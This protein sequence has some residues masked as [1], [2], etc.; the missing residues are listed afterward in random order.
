MK[1]RTLDQLLHVSGSDRV[2]RIKE[3][4]FLKSSC[5]SSDHPE[6][7]RAALRR[8]FVPIAYAHWE[9]YVKK[10][11]QAYLDYVACKK[12]KLRELKPC[13]QSIYFSIE[14]TKDLSKSKRHSLQGILNRISTGGDTRIHI[15]TKDVISTQGNLNSEVL[16]DICLNLGLSI[17]DFD[18]LIPFIDKIL[19]GKRNGI[20]HGESSNIS[21]ENIIDIAQKVIQCIDIFQ[22][23]ID[24]AAASEA[25]KA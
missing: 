25:F 4:T 7:K 10:V 16:E 15:K 17:S 12:L 24:N 20:A 8:A 1:I 23:A 22:N 14:N 13:F 18:A 5:I 6:Q 19:I 9:G 2:W 21:E 3:I 11:G